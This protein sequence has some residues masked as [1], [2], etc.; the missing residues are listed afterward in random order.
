M[1]RAH[2]GPAF[3]QIVPVM[4]VAE[5][6]AAASS[7]L[8][9]LLALCASST[10]RR[11][12]LLKTRPD[13]EGS[14]KTLLLQ[15]PRLHQLPALRYYLGKD[16][17]E[18]FPFPTFI[19]MPPSHPIHHHDILHQPPIMKLRLEITEI[20]MAMDKPH[21]GIRANQFALAQ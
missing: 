3:V 16:D 12:P 6:R 19:N 1:P 9:P 11:A 7:L 13:D 18:V 2:A 10:S 17:R 21:D 20:L 4:V 15:T 14:S 8:M 5:G